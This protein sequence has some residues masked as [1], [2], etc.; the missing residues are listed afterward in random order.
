MHASHVFH[1]LLKAKEYDYKVRSVYQ[2]IPI[3]S[4]A[5]IFSFYAGFAIL[6]LIH[7]K[8]VFCPKFRFFTKYQYFWTAWFLREEEGGHLKLVNLQPAW[9]K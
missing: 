8:K 5:N 7:L 2:L 1:L 3:L 9:L 4:S 6:Q